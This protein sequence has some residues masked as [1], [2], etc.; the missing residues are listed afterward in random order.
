MLNFLGEVDTHNIVMTK[1]KDRADSDPTLSCTTKQKRLSKLFY[2]LAKFRSSFEFCNLSGFYFNGFSSGSQPIH[3]IK[4]FFLLSVFGLINKVEEVLKFPSTRWLDC[5][6]ALI[7]A[8]VVRSGS[9]SS[10]LFW[11]ICHG[12]IAP[13]Y[14]AC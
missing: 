6:K 8:C 5:V 1:E 14:R 4:D 10:K 7:L 3:R 12:L 11:T 13:S 9:P 2:S